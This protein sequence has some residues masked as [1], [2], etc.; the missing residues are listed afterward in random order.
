MFSVLFSGDCVDVY[1]H[2]TPQQKVIITID[3]L[4]TA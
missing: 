1:L 3:P 2:D 4:A